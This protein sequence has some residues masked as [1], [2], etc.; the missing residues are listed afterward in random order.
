MALKLPILNQ[1]IAIVDPRTGYPTPAFV[2]YWNVDFIGAIESSVN[3]LIDV[4]TDLSAAIEQIRDVLEI[5][6]NAQETANNAQTDADS[7]GGGT[8]RSGSA[9]DP[10]VTLPVGVW[11]N[12]PQVDLTGVA[13]GTLTIPGSGPLQDD[14]V[15]LVGA[16]GDLVSFEFRIVEVILGV[17]EVLFTGTATAYKEKSGGGSMTTI[18]NGSSTDISA[19]SSARASTGDV[20][21]RIDARCAT[22]SITSLLLYVFARRS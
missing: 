14:D 6:Q 15:T 13:A 17:D 3:D 16:S 19:F 11:V 9:S 20:S 18:A 1:S 2:R 22:R 4:Q 7:A 10:A 21:Y 8:A 12:G 5:A